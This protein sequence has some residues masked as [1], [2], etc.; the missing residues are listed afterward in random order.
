MIKDNDTR[1]DVLVDEGQKIG[2][3]TAVRPTERRNKNGNVVWEWKC[4]CGKTV[5]RSVQDVSRYKNPSCGCQRLRAGEKIGMLTA[6]R[7]TDERKG[8]Y[9]VWEWKCDCGETVFRTPLSV[10]Q[11]ENR[12]YVPNCGCRKRKDTK[13]KEVFAFYL[14]RK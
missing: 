12:G 5:F 13:A 3:L 9:R 7:P 1:F 11:T 4:D 2:M 6:V 14:E 8:G 10:K